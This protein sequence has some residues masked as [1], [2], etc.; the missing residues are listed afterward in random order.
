MSPVG[1]THTNLSH[2][3][4][5]SRKA[6]TGD[7]TRNEREVKLHHTN[8]TRGFARCSLVV[9]NTFIVPVTPLSYF[10]YSEQVR[11]QD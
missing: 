2:R 1:F 4:A 8:G 5:S 11:R 3:V 6:Q 10:A 9:P 7:F